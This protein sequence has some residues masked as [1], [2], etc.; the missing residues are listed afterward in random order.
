VMAYLSPTMA[1][2]RAMVSGESVGG[3]G[4]TIFITIP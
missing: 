4:W 3:F 2:K 1:R